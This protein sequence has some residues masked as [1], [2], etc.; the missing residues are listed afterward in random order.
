MSHGHIPDMFNLWAD[1]VVHLLLVILKGSM[2]KHKI[3]RIL[4]GRGGEEVG[5]S[6]GIIPKTT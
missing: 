2:T 1:P 4:V 6:E 5:T 3:E